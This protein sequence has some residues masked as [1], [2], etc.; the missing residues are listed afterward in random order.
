VPSKPNPTLLVLKEIRDELRA[1]RQILHEHS[2]LFVEHGE[3]L[4][5]LAR[6]QTESEIRLSTEIVAVVKAVNQVH[7]VIRERLD[8]RARIQRIEGRLDA[9]EQRIPPAAE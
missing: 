9:L 3:K 1:H 4:S 7:D 6:R 5:A 8:D 2:A